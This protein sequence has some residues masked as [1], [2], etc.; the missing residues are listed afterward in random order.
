[1]HTN[2]SNINDMNEFS[3]I[4]L[5]AL[6]LNLTTSTIANALNLKALKLEPPTALNGIYKQD[7]YRR[8]QQYTR[9]LTNFH[10][11]TNTFNLITV[12]AFWFL[13][14]FNW[15][16]ELIISWSL[17]P[18][19]N[20]LLYIGILFITYNL[21]SIPFSI[22]A[23]FVIE[24]QF[25]FNKTT[26]RLF[27]TDRIKGLALSL[28][29]G[30]PLLACILALFEYTGSYAWLFCWVIV[31]IFLVVVQFI[32]PIWIMP[33]FNKFT[34]IG[35]GNLREGINNYI[36]SIG[37]K[38]NEIFAID[39]SKRSTKSNAFFTGFGRN[40]RIALFDTLINQ[41]TV[42]EIVAILA[43]EVGH[44]K[45]KHVLQGMIISILHTGI[46]LY[47]LSI[48][49]GFSGLHQAFYMEHQSIYTG[50]LFFS[51]V[52]TPIEMLLSI[53]LN[54]WSRRIEYEADRF[55]TQTIENPNSLIDALK[56]LSTHNLSNLTPHPFYVFLNYSHPPLLK[57][58]LAIQ[59]NSALLET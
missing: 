49:L 37:Y 51:L 39:G 48:F 24:E 12:L 54:I 43:H 58:I 4:I 56:K 52:Y 8:S 34:P 29:L 28:I 23:T 59:R 20:G 45:K 44:N 10:F 38:T 2:L 9:T 46:I 53:L 13:G 30:I 3:Y 22:Y 1:M 36:R 5:V 33:L 25:G 47:L 21:I 26:P 19:V 55:A 18:I 57:R 40:K 16:N 11:I 27:I 31:T 7:E 15:L 50:L 32:I 6:L 41:H 35:P 17:V 14:G 42:P